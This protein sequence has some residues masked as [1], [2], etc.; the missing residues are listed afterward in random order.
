[1]NPGINFTRID[2][3]S[4]GREAIRN[5]PK[6]TFVDDLG[7]FK[8]VTRVVESTLETDFPMPKYNLENTVFS[9]IGKYQ[10]NGTTV[11]VNR[12]GDENDAEYFTT[13]DNE[14]IHNQRESLEEELEFAKAYIK[15]QQRILPKSP[16]GEREL[17][18]AYG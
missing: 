8:R 5:M 18:R 9:I 14:I 1:M 17:T 16:K 15:S 4:F 11:E 2:P 3:R 12:L 10:Y 7:S 6:E 13:V